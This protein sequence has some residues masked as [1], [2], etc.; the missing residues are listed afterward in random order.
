MSVLEEVREI[1]DRLNHRPVFLLLPSK[2]YGNVFLQLTAKSQAI[3]TKAAREL[4]NN[5]WLWKI[6]LFNIQSLRVN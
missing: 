1:A 2:L 3:L 4:L 6:T 5:I